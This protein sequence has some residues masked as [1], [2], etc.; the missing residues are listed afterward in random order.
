[1]DSLFS[2]LKKLA[3]DILIKIP[4]YKLTYPFDM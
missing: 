1:M 4:K 2:F 3:H